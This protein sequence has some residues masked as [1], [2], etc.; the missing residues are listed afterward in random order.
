MALVAYVVA[1]QGETNGA[2]LRSYLAERLPAPLVPSAFVFLESLPLTPNGKLDRHI[3]PEPDAADGPE[4][5]DHAAPVTPLEGAVAQIWAGVLGL[6]RVGV[7]DDFFALGGH[8]LLATRIVARLR[9][10]FGVELPL[11]A[12]FEAPTVAGLAVVIT[13]RLL[14]TLRD[15]GATAR[16]NNGS[17]E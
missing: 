4:K 13:R 5:D 17:V 12:F 2:A 15:A 9:T 7:N 3:L 1:G 14:A 16:S 11:R 8:S 10:A 6:E